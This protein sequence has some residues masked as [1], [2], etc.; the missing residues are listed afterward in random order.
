ML[1]PLPDQLRR[2]VEH[3]LMGSAECRVDYVRVARHFVA[4]RIVAKGFLREIKAS[5]HSPGAG[6]RPVP[7]QL[8]RVESFGAADRMKRERKL[9]RDP[10]R[11]ENANRAVVASSLGL[12]LSSSGSSSLFVAG[13]I[14]TGC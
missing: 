14:A 4:A 5:E 8:V 3:I 2:K 10:S 1:A 12:R 13:V 11:M 7:F 9:K 6:A